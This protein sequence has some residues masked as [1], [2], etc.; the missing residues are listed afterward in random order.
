MKLRIK[1]FNDCFEGRQ[2]VVQKRVLL[3]FWVDCSDWL[4]SYDRAKTEVKKLK[5]LKAEGVTL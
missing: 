2:Y 3:L 4:S 1:T 5:R